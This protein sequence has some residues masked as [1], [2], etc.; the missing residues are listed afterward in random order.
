[1]RLALARVASNLCLTDDL[2]DASSALSIADESRENLERAPG[3]TPPN[4]EFLR[5]DYSRP[6]HDA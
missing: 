3:G 1:M 2:K 4:Y 6:C 5:R